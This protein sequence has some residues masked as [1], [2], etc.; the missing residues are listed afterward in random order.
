MSIGM[1]LRLIRESIRPRVSQETLGVRL[2]RNQRWVSQR[3]RGEVGCTVDEA[4]EMLR[5]LGFS[6]QLVVLP[7]AQSALLEAL[8]ELAPEASVTAVRLARVW[9]SMDDSM[10]EMLEHA[11]GLAEQRKESNTSS[12]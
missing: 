1:R 11:I 4:I 6:A 12:G 2:G 5:G 10:R 7:G 3:E 9:D 8:G